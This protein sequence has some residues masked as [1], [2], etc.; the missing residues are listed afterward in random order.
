M[1][2]Q[3]AAATQFYCVVE[4]SKLKEVEHLHEQGA[5]LEGDV[6][7]GT[8]QAVVPQ[9]QAMLA[10]STDVQMPHG[11]PAA[12]A[13]LAAPLGPSEEEREAKQ[14]VAQA[15][16]QQR[17]DE[18]ERRRADPKVKAKVWLTNLARDVSDAKR[19]KAI[20]PTIK[21][22]PGE[23][24]AEYDKM[25]TTHVAELEKLRTTIEDLVSKDSVTDEVQT[26]LSKAEATVQLFKQDRQAIDRLRQ[27]YGDDEAAP[28]TK[29]RARPKAVDA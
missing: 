22:L 23:L 21:R 15:K 17:K 29:G 9:I 16:A 3:G 12:Q 27:V 20:V 8:G 18:L 6:D 28:R 26:Q 7:K 5:A 24:K 10:G 1:S 19:Y 13:A 14:L 2:T 4:E 11:A 25:L